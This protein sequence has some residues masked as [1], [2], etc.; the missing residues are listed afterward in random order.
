VGRYVFRRSEYARDRR[1]DAYRATLIGF[2][3]AARSG[4]DMQSVFIQV[5][6]PARVPAESAHFTGETATAMRSA[7]EETWDRAQ[8]GRRMFEEAA[9]G[10]DLV[11]RDGTRTEIANLRG[12]LEDV[13]YSG[14]P[15]R[16]GVE[17]PELAPTRHLNPVDVEPEARQAV[18][19][20]IEQ[21]AADLWGRRRTFTWWPRRGAR[22]SRSELAASSDS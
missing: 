11:A 9:Y 2:L 17:P 14:S 21:G 3:A 10:A 4:A 1:L 7:Y 16:R 15:W 20:F 8:E 5:G 19:P 18:L 12:W 13:L 6:W 22:E